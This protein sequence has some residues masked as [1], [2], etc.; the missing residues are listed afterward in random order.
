MSLCG[1]LKCACWYH[2]G[3]PRSFECHHVLAHRWLDTVGTGLEN[4]EK[5]RIGQHLQK[6]FRKYSRLF[7]YL[8]TFGKMS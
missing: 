1:T 5:S 6:N 4:L 8:V 3:Q 2:D 7:S